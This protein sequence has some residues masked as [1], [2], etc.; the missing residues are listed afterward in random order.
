MNPECCGKEMI[1]RE[2]KFMNKL[3]ENEI[4]GYDC[5]VC[6]KKMNLQGEDIS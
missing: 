1:E 2:S 6:G 5:P 4:V 3:G